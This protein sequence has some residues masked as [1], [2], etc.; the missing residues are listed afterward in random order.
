[1]SVSKEVEINNAKFLV[2]LSS[3]NIHIR[4][5]YLVKNDAD[6][7]FVLDTIIASEEY[8]KFDYTRTKIS[9]LREW[10]AHNVLY[11]WGIAPSRTASV[12]LNENES[13]FRRICYFFLSKLEKTK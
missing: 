13:L 10:K 4:D 5:S 8:H 2:L 7:E 12:D 11:K 1:M 3:N 9:Y 6:K